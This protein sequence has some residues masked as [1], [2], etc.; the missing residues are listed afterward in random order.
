MLHSHVLA[1]VLII[2][3]FI[4]SAVFHTDWAT[5]D[6][7]TVEIRGYVK[8]LATLAD[9]SDSHIISSNSGDVQ[10]LEHEE[11]LTNTLRIN[12]LWRTDKSVSAEL[13]YEIFPRIA[14]DNIQSF[15]TLQAADP[16]SYRAF[17]FQK[18]VGITGDSSAFQLFHNLDRAF[19][20]FSPL[21]GDIH[22][23]RQPIAF[24]SAH[25]IN[26]TDILTSFS[27]T[28]LNKEE[29]IGVDAF[30]LKIPVGSLGEIDAGTVFGENFNSKESAA[31]LRA[32][33]F[34][35]ETDFSPI[36]ILFRENL[37]LGCD[38]AGSIGGAGYWF[39]GAYAFS[40]VTGNREA[41]MDYLRFSTGLDYSMTDK[42][43]SYIEYH[44]N[45][46][47]KN[48]PERYSETSNETA[49]TEGAVYLF[50]IHYIT[51]G[52]TY[53]VT[54]L[55]SFSAQAIYNIGDN[56]LLLFPNIGY[57]LSDN[58]SLEAGAFIGIGRGPDITE[59]SFAGGTDVSAR[60]EFGIYPDTYFISARYYF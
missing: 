36:A 13:A 9:F 52:F 1:S 60:S 27:Y 49:Y 51:P 38:I 30:R 40:G 24:G 50:G 16:F 25:V 37:L 54:P 29:R 22:V 4:F 21:F 34:I 53:E 46:A 28:E 3:S 26:P 7:N 42:L 35:F 56:S 31:F 17:D 55:I 43:Y 33:F 19:F 6:D 32:K 5:A 12:I 23:G 39:E 48:E 2:I 10:I 47:G 15:F 14:D 8:T 58:A 41:G 57:S 11:S 44:F 45:G 18:N 20:T 59:N